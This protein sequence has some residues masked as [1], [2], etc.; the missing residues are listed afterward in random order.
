[1]IYR[2]LFFSDPDWIR[3]NGPQLRRLLLYPLSYEALSGCKD[4]KT[5][6]NSSICY[7]CHL[8]IPDRAKAAV[9]FHIRLPESLGRH[10][11]VK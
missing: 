8:Q 11:A 9:V 5:F 6:Q 4:I 7:A 10:D 2:L 3:T 1:M